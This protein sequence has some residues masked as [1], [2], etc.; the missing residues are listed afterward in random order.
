MTT[1]LD[2]FNRWYNKQA[3]PGT[4]REAAHVAWLHQQA[5]IDRL[6]AQIKEV[7]WLGEATPPPPTDE[8]FK[9]AG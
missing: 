8:G 6:R 3:L 4:G 5:E 7:I 2:K 1:P 9:H